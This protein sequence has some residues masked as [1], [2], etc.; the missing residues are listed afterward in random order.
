MQK[1]LQTRL[2]LIKYIAKD[3][4]V[5]RFSWPANEWLVCSC[6][7]QIGLK[8]GRDRRESIEEE[9]RL[10][11]RVFVQEKISETEDELPFWF[12]E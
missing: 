10:V 8:T 7:E 4:V 11:D 3:L 2:R 9:L 5:K 12:Q 6:L 1:N